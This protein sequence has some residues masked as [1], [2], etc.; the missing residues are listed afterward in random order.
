MI[1]FI[2]KAK[3]LTHEMLLWIA[4]FQLTRL[5]ERLESE[6]FGKN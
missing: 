6:D 4:Y 1:I 2:G 3:D 5:I